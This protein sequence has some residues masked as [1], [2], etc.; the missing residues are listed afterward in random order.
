M[1]VCSCTGC[2]LRPLSLESLCSLGANSSSVLHEE[3]CD[4]VPCTVHP[5]NAPFAAGANSGH[6][7]IEGELSDSS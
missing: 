7:G 3:E 6:R 1:A 4:T 5:P 2:I